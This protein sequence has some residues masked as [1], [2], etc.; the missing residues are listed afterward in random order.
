MGL[1]EFPCPGTVGKPAPNPIRLFFYVLDSNLPMP[2]VPW[3]IGSLGLLQRLLA[4][5]A[6]HSAIVFLGYAASGSLVSF[7]GQKGPG[8]SVSIWQG[9]DSTPLHGTTMELFLLGS[10]FA[11]KVINS[12]YQPLC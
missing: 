12:A 1:Y 10:G 9:H 11:P 8:A 7:S 3:L 2:Q 4:L 6:G 5:P